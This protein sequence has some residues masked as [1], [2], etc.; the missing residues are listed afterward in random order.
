LVLT[1][2]H[3]RLKQPLE[4]A[5]GSP[6]ITWITQRR[7]RGKRL[8]LAYHGI[9][10]DGAPPAGERALFIPRRVFAAQLDM[11][12]EVAD[13]VSLTDLDEEGDGRPRVAITIDDAYAGTVREGVQE[14][15][16]RSLPATVFV[17]P[18]RLGGQ[19]FWWDALAHATGSLGDRIRHHA[20]YTLAGSEDRVR[21]WAA[22]TGLPVSPDLPEYARTATTAQLRAA[23]NHPGLTLASHTW[24][25]PNLASLSAGEI[26]SELARAREWLKVEF[27][28]RAIEWL[29]YPYGLDS[30]V[31][32]EAAAALSYTGA[33]RISGGW[34]TTEN[35]SRFA[36]PRL[37][38]S[39]KLSTNGLRARVLGAVRLAAGDR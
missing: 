39:S 32:N 5:L 33:L 24:S 20:L 31:A 34:H 18:G 3:S 8:I 23:L 10:P 4:R 30:N 38:V 16:V 36:R 14:L 26:S 6:G 35:V 22:R 29:A 7:L 28:G 37:N 2:M 12:S 13:V 19:T 1:G 11:L 15:A 9:I 27:G 21:E 25:H 17:A